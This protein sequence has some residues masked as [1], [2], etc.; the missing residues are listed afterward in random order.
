MT[1]AK[2]STG[3]ATLAFAGAKAYFVV[4]AYAI[5]LALPNILS[6]AEFGRY[7][8][9]LSG[10]SILN[11]VLIAA[12][13]QSVSKFVSADDASAPRLLQQGLR[14]QLV[15]GGLLSVA[16]YLL[17]PT[18]SGWLRDESLVP[19]VRVTAL[20]VFLY[21]LYGAMVGSLN[22][23][24]AFGTQAKLDAGFSTLR[25][26]GIVGGAALGGV[27]HAALAGWAGAVVFIA[28]A[29]L[30]VTR[31]DVFGRSGGGA[32]LGAW[33]SFMAP[34]WIYQLALNGMLL[35]DVQLLK[36]TVASLSELDAAGAAEVAS[37]QVAFYGGAQTFAMVPYQLIIALT[38]VV[39]PMVSRATT[40]GDEALARQTIRQAMRLS[41]LALLFFA[42][43][44]AGAADGVLRIAYPEPYLAGAGALRVLVFGLAAMGIFVVAATAIASANR[45]IVSA[46]IA[47]LGV[48]VVVVVARWRMQAVGLEGDVLVACA[49]G[50]TSGMSLALLLATAFLTLRFG[51]PF[52]PVTL[53]RV[54]IAAAAGYVTAHFV[55]HGN[56][57]MALVALAAGSLAYTLALVLTRELG[58]RDLD[59]IRG[60]LRK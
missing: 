52:P 27:A 26:A 21:A 20:V 7:R 48:V 34:I 18:L 24:R 3:R 16:L 41:L 44:I 42:A 33:L 38:F 39:F 55:P 43:P 47:G 30:L 31:K 35:I 49:T 51:F 11:N 57:W 15:L 4:T 40:A 10:V 54:A 1:S 53:L 12:T 45:P 28:T 37:T 59:A 9:V 32:P 13:I 5:Q 46:V 36:A 6:T 14:I 29:A 60:T 23:R 22:G 50:T 19:L 56:R 17:A 25:T 58:G 8:A 2:Q